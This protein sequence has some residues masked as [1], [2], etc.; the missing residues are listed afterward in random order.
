M[1][2]KVPFPSLYAILDPEFSTIPLPDL[3]AQLAAAGVEL[4]QLRDKR[5]PSSRILTA[6]KELN[7]TLA[8]KNTRFILNDRPDIAA[9]LR[10]RRPRRPGRPPV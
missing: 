9:I 2:S 7:A 6:A 4:I 1:S 10:L 8:P 3:A 5:S